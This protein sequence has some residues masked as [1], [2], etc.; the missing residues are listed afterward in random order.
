MDSKFCNEKLINDHDNAVN[1]V[2]LVKIPVDKKKVIKVK[3][4]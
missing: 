1:N 2:N 3:C 4:E